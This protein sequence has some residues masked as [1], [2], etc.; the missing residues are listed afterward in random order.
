MTPPKKPSNGHGWLW[1]AIGGLFGLGAV[2]L[3]VSLTAIGLSY[4]AKAEGQKAEGETAK[5]KVEVEAHD[6][7]Y[8]A[9]NQHVRESLERIERVQQTTQIDVRTTQEDVKAILRNRGVK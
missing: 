6:K 1:K 5:L 9:Q 4:D 8:E 3:T 2:L 7:A